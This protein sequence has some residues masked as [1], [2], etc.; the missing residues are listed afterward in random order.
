[1]G[2]KCFVSSNR[3]ATI[4]LLCRLNYVLLWKNN[5]G[6]APEFRRENLTKPL[7]LSKTEDISP[8]SL[9]IFATNWRN[10]S[11]TFDNALV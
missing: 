1:M 6:T 5:S 9:P 10:F 11:A 7:S 4:F 2:K 3:P 8:H